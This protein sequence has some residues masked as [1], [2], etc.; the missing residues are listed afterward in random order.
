L[1]R[2]FFVHLPDI[3]IPLYLLGFTPAFAS[4][5]LPLN[6][7]DMTCHVTPATLIGLGDNTTGSFVGIAR[8]VGKFLEVRKWP[9]EG[10]FPTGD[11]ARPHNT[12][13]LS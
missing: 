6:Q 3:I 8:T 12:A 1:V 10:E 7:T 2:I 11:F 13:F 9:T 5:P 4:I